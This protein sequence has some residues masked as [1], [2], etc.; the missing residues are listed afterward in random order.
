[1]GFFFLLLPGIP[2]NSWALEPLQLFQHPE[3]RNCAPIFNLQK[4]EYI[5][6]SADLVRAPSESAD[7]L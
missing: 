7:H 1:M 2:S 3:N 6:E 4:F 5:R